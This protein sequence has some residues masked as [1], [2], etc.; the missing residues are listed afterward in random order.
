MREILGLSPWRERLGEARRALRGDGE[1]PPTQFDRTSLRL[2]QPRLSIPVWL[3][4]RPRGRLVPISN[5]FNHLRPP[6]SSG[7]S[8]R[9]TAV[10]DFRGLQHTYDSHNGTDFATPPGTPVVAGAC[11]RVLRISREFDRGGL[12]IFLDHGRGL[13]T[14]SN[15]LARALVRVG[16]VVRRGQVIAL[17]GMSGL[18]GFAF[19]PWLVPHVHYNV[20]LDGEPVDPFARPG[21]TPIWRSGN[22]PTTAGPGVPTRALCYEPTPFDADAVA[23]A[24]SKCRN[25]GVR[26]HLEAIGDLGER[27][28]GVLFQANY[29]PARF[30]EP[31]SLYPEP[32]PRAPWL[33]LPFRRED[34]D[35][36]ALDGAPS[37]P[38]SPIPAHT[39]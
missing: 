21:E 13:V 2:L 22:E 12:K 3:G 28:M 23:H 6:A 31:V 15:H 11:G 1:T 18:D 39:S 34:Y 10:R 32:H 27:A 29:Y 25:E 14:S 16:E 37:A 9:V 5:L 7:W 33:D 26:R 38:D 8:V 20:W 30:P 4:R 19:F 36:V 24:I 35:G 17:S